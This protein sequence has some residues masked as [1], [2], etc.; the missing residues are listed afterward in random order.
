M[1]RIFIL[2]P[3][4]CGKGTQAKLLGEHLGIPQLS[5]GGLL[6]E[7]ANKDTEL[8]RQVREIV[9]SGSLVSDV[10]AEAVLRERLGQSDVRDGYILDG[11]PRNNEQFSAFSKFDQ[12]TAVIVIK[13][14]RDESIRRLMKRAVTEGRQDDTPE[15]M[16]KRLDIYETETVPIIKLYEERGIVRAVDGVGT[17]EEVAER[18]RRTFVL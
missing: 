11:F 9:E 2:G 6:R 15:V 14:D 16:A 7:A 4:G 8:G 13:I 12:P 18:I 1:H 17:V 10:I 5:M 3:Q